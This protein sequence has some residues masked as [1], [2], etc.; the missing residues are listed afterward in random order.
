MMKCSAITDATT[1]ET[2]LE[3]CPAGKDVLVK[4]FGAGVTLPGRTWTAEPLLKA[5]SIRGVSCAQVLQDLHT[6]AES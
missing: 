1:V 6:L 4:H 5:C 3:D 2:I